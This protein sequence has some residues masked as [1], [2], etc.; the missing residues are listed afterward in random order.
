MNEIIIKTIPIFLI[1][2][3]GYV[4]KR[5]AI[6]K[7][8]DGDLFLKTVFYVAA[9]ALILLSVSKV[10]LQFDFIFL[11]VIAIL[12]VLITYGVSY[13]IGRKLN[14]SRQTFGVF[15]VGPMIMNTHFLLPFIIAE[16]GEEGMAIFSLFDLGVALLAFTFVYYLA[17]KY[18][19]NNRN[20]KVMIKKF[21]FSPLLLSLVIAIMINL[22]DLS[23]PAVADNFFRFLSNLVTPLVMLSLGIYFNL[24]ITRFIPIVSAILIRMP[25]GF[26]LGYVFCGIFG[27]DGLNKI[28]V[29]VMSAAPVG[30]NTLTF[31]SLENLDKE[32]AAG[33]ISLSILSGFISTS[34]IIIFFS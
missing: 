20:S 19:T 10:E 3:L 17:C 33:L 28:L 30:Y 23:I 11:P 26:M 25:F 5:L 32:F 24:S 12:V 16:Y 22:A 4:L 21:I 29:L 8:E 9:P 31:S 15:L 18:G 34:L 2:L 1:F 13:F 6:L 7:K 27:L 14:L